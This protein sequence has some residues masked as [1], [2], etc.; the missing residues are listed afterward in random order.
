MT[1]EKSCGFVAYTEANGER[2]YL[3]I[4]SLNGDYG[5]PK[6][7]TELGETEYKTAIR[8]LKE[9]TGAEAQIIE[10]FRKQIEYR[11]PKKPDTTKQSVYFLG[12]LDNTDLICQATEVAEALLLSLEKALTIL[13]F[14]DTKEILKEADVYLNSIKM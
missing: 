10:G 2:L 1:Y 3:I 7:H 9:E 12:K 5:F 6:G 13:S 4:H 8:E 14:D 11:L